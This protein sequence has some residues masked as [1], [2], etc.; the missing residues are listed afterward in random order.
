ML[1]IYSTNIASLVLSP[2]SI[3]I[4]PL[5]CSSI[6]KAA[7]AYLGEERFKA[8]FKRQDLRKRTPNTLTT[9]VELEAECEKIRKTGVAFDARYALFAGIFLAGA[10]LVITKKKKSV[11][12]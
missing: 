5:Y 8:Y 4:S 1:S 10:C 12:L 11:K 9:Q 7:L 3:P 2:K 6:G